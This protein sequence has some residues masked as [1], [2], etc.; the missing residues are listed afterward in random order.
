MTAQEVLN[1]CRN[2]FS[3]QVQEFII[4]LSKIRTSRVSSELITSL[5]ISAY[6]Q[7]KPLKSLAQVQ[8]EGALSLLVT[9]Y[10]GSTSAAIEKALL[11]ADLSAG[12]LRTKDLIR[13]TFSP[14]TQERRINL[15]KQLK[16]D[17][18]KTLIH[19]RNLRREAN[20]SLKS[21]KKEKLISE[22]EEKAFEKHVKK[23]LDE[24]VTEVE[25]S[26]NKKLEEV[27]K[28]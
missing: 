6:G 14:M 20:E 13:V 22:D 3:E 10:D 7:S 12:V 8:T 21:L 15:C 24:A 17:S 9:P 25:L 28:V 26:L 11:S 4:K 23:A 19:L 18:E 1:H 5:M 16:Q 2:K 27:M